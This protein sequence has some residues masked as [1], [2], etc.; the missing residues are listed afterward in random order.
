[1]NRMLYDEH[2]S[3]L[4]VELDN[5]M[6][7]VGDHIFRIVD[8]DFHPGVERRVE[9]PRMQYHETA[10]VADVDRTRARGR[11]LEADLGTTF[12]N[13][14]QPLLSMQNEL[15]GMIA[16]RYAIDTQNVGTVSVPFDVVRV[17][18]QV[19][20]VACASDVVYRDGRLTSAPEASYRSIR[21]AVTRSAPGFLD[22]V[23][24]RPMAPSE[25]E[26]VVA[27]LQR[28]AAAGRIDP[29]LLSGYIE[30]L[31]ARTVHVATSATVGAQVSAPVE[32]TPTV[33]I[34]PS[35]V[36][37]EDAGEED[38]DED[39]GEEDLD[40]DTDDEDLDE[41][42]GDEDLDEDAGD[43]DL[44][45]DAGDEDLDEDADDEDTDGGEAASRSASGVR[46]VILDVGAQPDLVIVGL[47]TLGNGLDEASVRASLASLPYTLPGEFP[48]AQAEKIRAIL[49]RVGASVDLLDGDDHE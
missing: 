29:G 22:D 34:G 10:L 15:E 6:R 23:T 31:R 35:Q 16:N 37:D 46:I 45:E 13:V 5:K 14:V 25:V 18:D 9:V 32:P 43:E 33:V 26:S 42:A 38:L 21:D 12:V 27:A 28:L 48:A 40:E 24:L 7:T 19:Q 44:D 41:D 17:R 39:A 11:A 3:R 36:V 30:A 2:F 20:E 47:R 4:I 1:M 49:V 8:E